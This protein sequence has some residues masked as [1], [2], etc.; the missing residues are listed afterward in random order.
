MES[1]EFTSKGGVQPSL[2]RAVRG[3]VYLLIT[4]FAALLRLSVT[5]IW[6]RRILPESKTLELASEKNS[7][8][9]KKVIQD[10]RLK[11][12]KRLMRI[13]LLVPPV[14]ILILLLSQGGFLCGLEKILLNMW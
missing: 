5:L 7:W 2:W 4:F 14:Y 9:W 11:F 6:F 8:E 1:F 3:A 10:I 12:L 13:M